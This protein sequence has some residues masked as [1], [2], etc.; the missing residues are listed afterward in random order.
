MKHYF[1]ITFIAIV[2]LFVC[3][4]PGITPPNPNY[5]SFSIFN[6]MVWG[7]P[8]LTTAFVF[9]MI[10][11]VTSI[12]ACVLYF[13]IKKNASSIIFMVSSGVNSLFYL[14]TGIL[15][16]CVVPLTVGP[17]YQNAGYNIGA[18]SIF[19]GILNIMLSI[20][21]FICEFFLIKERKTLPKDTKK[22]KV[23]KTK[24]SKKVTTDEDNIVFFLK[25]Y[26]SLLDKEI[27]TEAEYNK[28]KDKLL[29]KYRL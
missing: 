2:A 1:T 20:A 18:G 5:G 7:V 6:L 24:V 4:A 9:Y 3:F 16:L 28:L 12:V 10:S 26:K 22:G 14:L 8:G 27:I 29:E 13:V 23:G 15:V 17:N 11:L 21:S 19:F 25:K